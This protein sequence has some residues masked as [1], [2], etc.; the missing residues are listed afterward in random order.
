MKRIVVFLLL[1]C[2]LSAYSQTSGTRD[3]LY[4]TG[5]K[6]ATWWMY[7]KFNNLN[8]PLSVPS[9]GKDTGNIYF[10]PVTKKALIYDGVTYA[11][12]FGVDSVWK[13]SGGGVDTLKYRAFGNTYTVG[14]FNGS[15]GDTTSLSNRINNAYNSVEGTSDSTGL[16]F[17]KP[18]GGRDTVSI[19]GAMGGPGSGE[20]NTASNV[21]T[22]A[23]VF[24]EKSGVDFRFR[25]II[26]SNGITVTQ[27]SDDITISPTIAVTRGTFA[28]RPASP[29]TG[30]LYWQTDRLAGQWEYDG[31]EWRFRG[32][33]SKFDFNETFSAGA[34][35]SVGRLTGLTG[36]T[37][38]TANIYRQKGGTSY[39][40]LNTGTTTTG[41][42]SYQI[43]FSEET[44]LQL[45]SVITYREFRVRLP[46]LSD[47]TE[48]YESAVGWL[49][50]Q[51]LWSFM[52]LGFHYTHSNN[53]GR[54]ETRTRKFDNSA[55]MTVKDTGVPVVAGQWYKMGIEVNGFTN[56]IY[57]YIDDVLVATHTSAE[58][59]PVPNST[60]NN[61]YNYGI[62]KQAGTTARVMDVDYAISYI[63]KQ[64][65]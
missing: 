55:N 28:Q 5:S 16:I 6:S 23:E 9:S 52:T 31:I 39:L 24:K 41:Y 63:V 14:T 32:V 20:V 13:V 42:S 15:G 19:L 54:W 51:S 1:L 47:G 25:S 61:Q 30:Q 58:N 18:N 3:G 38:S 17:I 57:F 37:A 59:I 49:G 12:Y 62:A 45:D 34:T 36:G 4:V 7:G 29:D 8:L 46:I 64:S 27:N 21:G 33:A 48:T 43:A 22:G 35:S 44:V 56:T 53:G 65:Y 26:G 50:H 2:S 60:N 11:S 10:N 40:Q